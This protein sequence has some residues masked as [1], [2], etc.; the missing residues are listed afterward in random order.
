[1]EHTYERCH[2]ISHTPSQTNTQHKQNAPCVSYEILALLVGRRGAVVDAVHV[3]DLASQDGK[4]L[5]PLHVAATRHVRITQQ[6]HHTTPR[7]PPL[8]P[9]AVML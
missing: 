8:L 2:L 5:A 9:H 7:H 1:M 6:A 4:A 3:N